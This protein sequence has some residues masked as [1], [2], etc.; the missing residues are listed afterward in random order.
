MFSNQQSDADHLQLLT[1]SQM[2][3][4]YSLLERFRLTEHTAEV[5]YFTST[6]WLELLLCICAFLGLNCGMFV[7]QLDKLA[8]ADTLAIDDSTFLAS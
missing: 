3:T 8:P 5:P 6:E 2:F 4:V 7:A 1:L